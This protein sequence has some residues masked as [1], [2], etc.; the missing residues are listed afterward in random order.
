MSLSI[1]QKQPHKMKETQQAPKTSSN[2]EEGAQT[3][4]MK[5]M[6]PPPFQLAASPNDGGS[7][8]GVKSKV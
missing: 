4:Q 2:F 3:T 8:G 1:I 6:A 5:S 7:N